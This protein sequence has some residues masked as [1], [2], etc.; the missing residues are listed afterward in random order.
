VGEGFAEIER[1][2]AW[3]VNDRQWRSPVRVE[4]RL[5]AVVGH[6]ARKAWCIVEYKLSRGP[7]FADLGQLCIYR[8]ML[9]GVA[10]GEGS[11]ALVRFGDKREETLYS[12]ADFSDVRQRLIELIG[13]LAAVN[14]GP[15]PLPDP[16]PSHAQ[17]G[18]RLVKALA[19]LG[20]PA[21]L[22]GPAIHGP[23]FL[24]FPLALERGIRAAAI[25]KLGQEFAGPV[26]P[27]QAASAGHLRIGLGGR[28]CS[29]AGSA[30]GTVQ[31]GLGPVTAARRY[32]HGHAL[33]GRRGH[34]GAPDLV[35]SGGVP[36]RARSRHCR[37]R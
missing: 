22:A 3:L 26:G 25:L 34:R 28:R 35:K 33:S 32:R 9:L 4:G 11:I 2:L 24:R 10:G 5:D 18:I 17:L 7:S 1:P 6:P 8:E 12:G 30:D 36:A 37:K 27:T 19:E 20:A 21:R 23:A 14:G 29:A 15:P 31:P 13:K 16:D